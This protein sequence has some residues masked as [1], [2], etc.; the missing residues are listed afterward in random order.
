[1]KTNLVLFK[2]ASILQFTDNKSVEHILTFGSR[3]P[4]IQEIV[5]DIHIKCRLYGI[6]LAARWMS[7]EEEEMR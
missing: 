2:K 7:R 1:M 4:E 6:T 3:N 5:F